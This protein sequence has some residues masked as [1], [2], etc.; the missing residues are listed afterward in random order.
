MCGRNTNYDL[1]KDQQG[2]YISEQ[3]SSGNGK[4]KYELL[5]TQST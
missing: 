5:R 3:M 1:L 2:S 4:D